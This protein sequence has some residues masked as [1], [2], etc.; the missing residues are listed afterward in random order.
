MPNSAPC[1]PAPLATNDHLSFEA[2]GLFVWMQAT[3][4]ALNM[5]LAEMAAQGNTSIENVRLCL[6]E[7]AAYGYLTSRPER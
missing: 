5:T 2:R 6:D 4:G 3:P 1:E 7:L